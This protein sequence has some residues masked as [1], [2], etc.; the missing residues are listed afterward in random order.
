MEIRLVKDFLI[1]Q[2]HKDINKTVK[3]ELVLKNVKGKA[4]TI[5]G[6]R[7]AGRTKNLKMS[8]NVGF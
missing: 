1:N 5:I 6:P 3:R 7:R 8:K 2:F 4:T